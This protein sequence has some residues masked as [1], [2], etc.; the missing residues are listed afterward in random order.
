MDSMID[1]ALSLAIAVGIVQKIVERV[2]VK[3]P[4]LDGDLVTLA[5]FALG[6]AMSWFGGLRASGVL[7]TGNIPVWLD[8][9]VTAAVIALGS[10]VLAD[11]LAP[12][13]IVMMSG[14]VDL[15]I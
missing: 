2:R 5:A 14:P 10:G 7:I 6:A 11:F 13:P 3:L 12:K 15:D 1:M 9:V 4:R 8:V